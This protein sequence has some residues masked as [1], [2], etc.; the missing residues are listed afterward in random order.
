[1][2]SVFSWLRTQTK[3]A[4]LAGFGDAVAEL[5]GDGTTDTEPVLAQLRR[6]LQPALTGPSATM[7]ARV[8][9]SASNLPQDEAAEET[10]QTTNHRAK[11]RRKPTHATAE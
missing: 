9:A 11:G 10:A 7:P 4:V 8:A 1:M 6:R 5:E 2:F 3:N